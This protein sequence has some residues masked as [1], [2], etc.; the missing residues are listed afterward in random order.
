MHGIIPETTI[1]L[2]VRT[3]KKFSGGQ[4]APDRMQH[5]FACG[6]S[7]G[8]GFH[9]FII[10]G[11]TGGHM[12]ASGATIAT[13]GEPGESQCQT[14]VEGLQRL[15]LACDAAAFIFDGNAPVCAA[16]DDKCSWAIEQLS[17]LEKLR[18]L[19]KKRKDA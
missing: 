6:Y 19:D 1:R 4:L 15:I 9:I 3:H 14:A 8:N 12:V 7:L 16:I 18:E 10:L 5:E 17:E 11:V 2:G 13:M